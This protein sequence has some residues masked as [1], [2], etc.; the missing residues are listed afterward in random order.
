MSEGCQYVT[1][2]SC[3]GLLEYVITKVPNH[4]VISIVSFALFYLIVSLLE[5]LVELLM[6]LFR[7]L[8]HSKLAI[9]RLFL[10]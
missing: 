7:S 10:S 8:L 6:L 2:Y 4:C 3:G 1:Y 9:K 5:S